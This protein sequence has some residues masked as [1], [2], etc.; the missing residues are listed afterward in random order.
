MRKKIN[1]IR[2]LLTLFALIFISTACASEQTPSSDIVGQYKSDDGV[3]I[4]IKKIDDNHYVLTSDHSGN[5]EEAGHNWSGV[6]MMDLHFLR[7][8]T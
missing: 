6:G 8:R 7:E 1:V 5:K 2:M 3:L 4:H